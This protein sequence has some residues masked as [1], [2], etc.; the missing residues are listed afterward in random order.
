MALTRIGRPCHSQG[1]QDDETAFAEEIDLA[2]V[3][4]EIKARG[5]EVNA[6]VASRLNVQQQE[7]DLRQ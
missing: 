2:L 1:R 5:D 4:E 3:P 6:R 7:R